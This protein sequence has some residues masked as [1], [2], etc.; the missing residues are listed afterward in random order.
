MK[1]KIY[2]G[3]LSL[4]ICL[5]WGKASVFATELPKSQSVKVGWFES[6]GY[7]EKDQK[8]NLIG[9]GVDYLNA[10]AN[11]TGWEYEFVEGTREECLNMLQNG[12]I[13]LREFSVSL[14]QKFCGH[15]SQNTIT[16]KLQPLIAAD[17]GIAVFIGIGAV[18]KCLT[19]KFAVLESVLQLFLQ[20]FH[21][22]HSFQKREP[23]LSDEALFIRAS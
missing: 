14:K 19:E 2:F 23:R 18:V 21:H 9:F 10:I 3:I 6:A 13:T 8:N 17:T 11:Y 7:F 15:K 20:G 12:E 4:C 5:L 16:Q 1:R 22:R